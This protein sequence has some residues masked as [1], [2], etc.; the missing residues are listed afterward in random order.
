MAA[1][2]VT[3][4][5]GR[6]EYERRRT[7][8][9]SVLPE[10]SLALFPSSPVARM[11]HDV[12]YH[13]HC[14]DSDLLYLCGLQEHSSLLACAK[15][16]G[17]G[18]PRWHLFVRPSSKEE[19]LWEGAHAGVEGARAHFLPEGEAHPLADAARVLVAELPPPPHVASA[20]GGSAAAG[21]KGG[22][23]AAAF[24][25][26]TRRNPTWNSRLAP[27]LDAVSGWAPHP[28]A[29]VSPSPMVHVLRVVK[30]AAE[31]EL[32]RRSATLAS[33]AMRGTMVGSIDAARRGLSEGVLAAQF[34]F[35][36]RLGGAE[37]LAYPSV[38]ACGS[39]ATTLHYFHN[40]EL[41]RP[42]EMLLMDAGA[43]LHGYSSDLTRTWPLSGTF[44]PAQRDVYAAVL[45]VQQRVLTA[46]VSDGQT[47]L[48][49]L[50]RQSLHWMHDNL[51]DLGVMA[52]GEPSASARVKRY[53]PHNISHWLG[54][55]VH[56]TPSVGVET[57]LHPGMALT[58]EPGLYFP[59]DDESVPAWC[60]G[61][62][63]RI[64]DDAI[65]RGG[66]AGVEPAEVLTA[67]TPKTVDEVE[68]LLAA[69]LDTAG[70][71]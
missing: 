62:G 23:R 4:G 51:V 20:A 47:S 70:S 28:S 54:L 35:E 18:K 16:L 37:R 60:R 13:P 42:D 67:A 57:K 64:E 1:G 65:V 24:Y 68:A 8:L 27:L 12:K 58:V 53:Y 21:A 39:N 59:L 31:V 61:I 7:R 2:E 38:V 63:V 41:L 43:S 19:E 40:D 52:R 48:G 25:F 34:E 17:G 46:C 69:A 14:Q 56:D 66:E 6:A 50:Y 44:S 11:S 3:P 22:G 33:S 45:D 49:T 55:D 29:H 30:S 9:A 71:G 15:P 36:C 10:G 5:I 32:M 26:D